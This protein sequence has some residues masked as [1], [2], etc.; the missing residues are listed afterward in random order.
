[1]K[2]KAEMYEEI[3][4]RGDKEEIDICIYQLEKLNMYGM[5]TASDMDSLIEL[6]NSLNWYRP[7]DFFGILDCLKPTNLN[8]FTK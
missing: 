5:L 3:A 7:V 4:E 2:T 6:K 8:K 1:M